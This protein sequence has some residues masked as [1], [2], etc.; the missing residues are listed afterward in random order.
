MQSCFNL[1]KKMPKDLQI[2]LDRINSKRAMKF[3]QKYRERA[4][5]NQV[6]QNVF[7]EFQ[8]IFVAVSC[9]QID[10]YHEWFEQV[11]ALR[12]EGFLCVNQ[13]FVNDSLKYKAKSKANILAWKLFNAFLL[14]RNENPFAV[15]LGMPKQDTLLAS[16]E[17]VKKSPN[18]CK[19]EQKYCKAQRCLEPLFE[20][21]SYV[22]VFAKTLNNFIQNAYQF[23][24]GEI[25]DM[26]NPYTTIAKMIDQY[27]QQYIES[28]P[29]FNELQK[30]MICQHAR[31][32]AIQF[33]NTKIRSNFSLSQELTLRSIV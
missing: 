11:L 19:Q 32:F 17:E 22:D 31:A 21:S 29:T 9:M 2:A 20:Y 1:G 10:N 8:P 33:L 6:L 4:Y 28:E 7:K 27:T 12:I 25:C 24:P 23:S 30:G 13:Y 3:T 16:P 14:H 26:N 18:N 5:C 15:D